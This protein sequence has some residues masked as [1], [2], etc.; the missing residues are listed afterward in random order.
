MQCTEVR[1]R[2]SGYKDGELVP[3]ESDRVADHLNSCPDCRAELAA[4][5]QVDGWLIGLPEQAMPGNAPARMAAVLKRSADVTTAECGRRGIVF[6]C[7]TR[8]E[9]FFDALWPAR[10]RATRSLDAFEDFPPYG[11]G[12]IYLSLLD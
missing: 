8:L 12:R 9:D 5:E 1:E 6:R 11:L 2:L 10:T 4:L 7:L 3:R